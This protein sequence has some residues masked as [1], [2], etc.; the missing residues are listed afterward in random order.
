MHGF[1]AGASVASG[2]QA[3]PGN[4]CDDGQMSETGG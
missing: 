1:E 3:E 4:Q 2:C